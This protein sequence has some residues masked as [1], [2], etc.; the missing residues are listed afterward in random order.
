[1]RMM[2]KS[3]CE[4]K[5]SS[6][7]WQTI[8]ENQ[9]FLLSDRLYFK[10]RIPVFCFVRTVLEQHVDWAKQSWW[11]DRMFWYVVLIQD[12]I[13]Y[14]SM[15]ESCLSAW[16]EAA[17]S[18]VLV[19]AAVSLVLLF[20]QNHGVTAA[21]GAALGWQICRWRNTNLITVLVMLLAKFSQLHLCWATLR[22][23]WSQWEF[24]H[25]LP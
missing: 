25:Q 16:A 9:K 24:C 1:M 2:K 10:C 14:P 12:R 3:L 21:R 15:E 19:A 20:R 4:K 22:G 6:F 17:A 13:S 23:C 5:T 11:Y 8:F 7:N 18:P